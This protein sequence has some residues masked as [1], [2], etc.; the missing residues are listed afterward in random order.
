MAGGSIVP[1]SV[2][3]LASAQARKWAL[4]KLE[5]DRRIN[6]SYTTS[7]G[8]IQIDD[9]SIVAIAS[10]RRILTVEGS[11]VDWAMAD[12]VSVSLTSVDI[13]TML[14][15]FIQ[16]QTQAHAASQAIRAAIYAADATVE[17]VG[18]IDPTSYPWPVAAVVHSEPIEPDEPAGAGEGGETP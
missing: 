8:P 15:E 13:D 3:T 12:N 6:G 7:F 2:E 16:F 17:T 9:R 14:G 4:T 18:A 1:D 11:T 10:A 5:R